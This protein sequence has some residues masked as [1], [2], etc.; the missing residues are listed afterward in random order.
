MPFLG[1]AFGCVTKGC[2]DL[3]DKLGIKAIVPLILKTTL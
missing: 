2:H 1:V 3:N